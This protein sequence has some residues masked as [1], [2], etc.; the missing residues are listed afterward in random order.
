[1]S[2][3]LGVLGC[4]SIARAAHLRSLA[5][6]EGAAVVAVADSDAAN[7]AAARP[8][9]PKAHAMRN[10]ADVLGLADLDAVVIALPPGLHADAAIMAL[11][12]GK[13]VYV[14]KPLATNVTD[15]ERVVAAWKGSGLTAMMG[16]NYRYNPIVQRARARLA[17]GAVGTVVGVRTVFATPRRAI[18]AWKQQRDTGGGVLLDLAVHHVDLVRFLLDTEVAHVSAE[19]HSAASDQDT[20]FLQLRLTNGITVQSMCSLGAVDEDRI[21]IYGSSAKLTIDRYGSLRAEETP[22]TPRGALQLAMTRLVGEMSAAPYAL[23][24]LRAP[25]HDPSFPAAMS[26]FVRAVERRGVAAPTLGDGFRALAVIEAAELS[27]RTRRVIELDVQP[28]VA[29]PH[30]RRDAARV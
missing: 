14:E 4:G 15:G 22:V 21:E 25:L 10:Y 6:I 18:P 2:V 3:R 20:A 28:A 16:F 7:L 13:H 23:A 30:A 12:R 19:V 24:K 26:A 5:R 11:Q 9:A 8:L 17:A 27:A 29:I 1:M